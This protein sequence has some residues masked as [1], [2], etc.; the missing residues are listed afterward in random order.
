MHT[1]LLKANGVLGYGAVI[2]SFLVDARWFVV[3]S[4]ATYWVAF[5]EQD[6][7]V[8]LYGDVGFDTPTI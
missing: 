4:I 7:M 1:V 6:A 3:L 5:T 8:L 2:A